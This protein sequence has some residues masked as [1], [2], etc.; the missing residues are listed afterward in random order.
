MVSRHLH[1]WITWSARCRSAGGIVRP[2]ALAVLRLM[3]YSI[4]GLAMSR[5]AATY[6]DRILKGAKPGDLAIYQSARYELVVN[7]RAAE[8]YGIALPREFVQ[9]ADRVIR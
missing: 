3:T 5:L 7:L 4:D 6:V 8:Q 1:Y 2:R 9:R